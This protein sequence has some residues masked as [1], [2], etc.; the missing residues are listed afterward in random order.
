MQLD[1]INYAPLEEFNRFKIGGKQFNSGLLSIIFFGLGL[2]C[3]YLKGK[4][5]ILGLSFVAI[6]AVIYFIQSR[7]N[8]Q[9]WRNFAAANSWQILS[10]QDGKNSLPACLVGE[11]HSHSSS[12]LITGNINNRS[13]NLHS[14]TYKTGYGKTEQTHETTIIAFSY[15]QITN[16]MLLAHDG[17]F[18]DA[19]KVFDGGQKLDLE[20]DFNKKFTFYVQQGSEVDSLQIITPDIMQVLVKEDFEYNVE[21]R[22]GW[23]F[24]CVFGDQRSPKLLK[25]FFKNALDTIDELQKNYVLEH[26][27]ANPQPVSTT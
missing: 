9:Y 3:I 18:A 4:F 14:Y 15:P 10:S 24:F 17:I 16:H 20:G 1:Q 5:I 25:I 26:P 21:F 12:E 23:I 22:N 27:A 13:F 6:S 2:L 19:Y 7:K 11:G 8:K